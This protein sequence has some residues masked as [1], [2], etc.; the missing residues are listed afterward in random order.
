MTELTDELKATI[1]S[2]P[3]EALLE[4]IRFA[5]PG[6]LL[7]QPPSGDYVMAR[8]AELRDADP[9]AHTAASKRIGW[10]R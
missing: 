4:K 1:D 10:D 2:W 6:S 3:I 7:F 5:P 9:A 8:Y